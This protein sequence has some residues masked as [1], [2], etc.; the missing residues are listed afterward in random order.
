MKSSRA[1]KVRLLL[2]EN[3]KLKTEEIYRAFRPYESEFPQNSAQIV[4]QSA[5][6]N[7]KHAA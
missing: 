6:L 7:K 1:E 3:M 2:Y 4:P 5:I